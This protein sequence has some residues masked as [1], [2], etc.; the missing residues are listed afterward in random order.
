MWRMHP[1]RIRRWHCLA[2]QLPRLLDLPPETGAELVKLLGRVVRRVLRH[3]LAGE[4]E[5]LRLLEGLEQRPGAAE[6]LN[7]ILERARLRG[8]RP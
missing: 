8:G 6:A 4:R 1:L 7:R 3:R 5:L 2:D